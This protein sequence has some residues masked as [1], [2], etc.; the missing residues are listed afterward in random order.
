MGPEMAATA[1][2]FQVAMQPGKR[3]ALLEPTE[4]RRQDLNEAA[5]AHDRAKIEHPFEEIKH[6]FRFQENRAGCTSQETLQNQCAGST[7]VSLP[8]PASFACT[9]ITWRL[10]CP[11]GGIKRLR[12]EL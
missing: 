10:V 8:G 2:E 11:K 7:Y 1:A 6:Q 12:A 5:K 3:R 4:G 9:S